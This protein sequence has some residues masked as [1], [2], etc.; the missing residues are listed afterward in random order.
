M[1]QR[2]HPRPTVDDLLSVVPT[3]EVDLKFIAEA[4]VSRQPVIQ[5]CFST[6]AFY[7]LNLRIYE[8]SYWHWFLISSMEDLYERGLVE[9]MVKRL[10]EDVRMDLGPRNYSMKTWL[11]ANNLPEYDYDREEALLLAKTLFET[12][13]GIT[14]NESRLL[15]NI[16]Q[17]MIE[18]MKQLSSYSIQ[19]TREINAED[20]VVI[21]PPCIRLGNQK[22]GQSEYREHENGVL[23]LDGRSHGM[24]YANIGTDIETR[25]IPKNCPS[26][27]PRA[28]LIDPNLVT[29]GLG[30]LETS[31]E[32]PSSPCYIDITYEGQNVELEAKMLLP[33][34]TSFE[35]LPESARLKLKSKYS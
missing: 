30:H 6:S 4:I 10:Y 29:V 24:S 18:L 16:Q 22:M 13:T 1:Q 23:V 8:E 20:I 15:K 32:A 26:E 25:P 9:N 5:P 27:L 19:F 12:A 34:Y 2:I 11:A 33:G 7:N 14:V 35:K 21:N 28:V 3:K 31:C 17:A